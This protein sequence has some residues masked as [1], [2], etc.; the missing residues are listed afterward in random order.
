MQL[1][2]LLLNAMKNL[3]NEKTIKK[4][5]FSKIGFPSSLR[6]MT[7]VASLLP[8]HTTIIQNVNG[9]ITSQTFMQC[10][11]LHIAWKIFSHLHIQ[12]IMKISIHMQDHG[13]ELQG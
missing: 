3:V 11:P 1:L 6:I 7:V 4:I 5:F 2:E 13:Y 10:Y 8:S 9:W 12:V